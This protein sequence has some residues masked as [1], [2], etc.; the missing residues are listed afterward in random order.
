MQWIVYLLATSKTDK[1]A[2]VVFIPL[3]LI[4]DVLLYS[5]FR[6]LH[7]NKLIINE[8]DIKYYERGVKTEIPYAAITKIDMGMS[9]DYYLRSGT[10][11]TPVIHYSS[12]GKNKEFGLPHWMNRKEILE[13]I[14][15]HIKQEIISNGE[16]KTITVNGRGIYH[17]GCDGDYT[18]VGE[19]NVID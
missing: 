1:L 3:A 5:V 18:K 10:I 14:L 8:S 19:L 15:P 4:M 13:T 12:G 6:T 17:P 7:G 9:R 11:R 2:L 16:K